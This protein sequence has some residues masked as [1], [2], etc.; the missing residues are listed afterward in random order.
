VPF[1]VGGGGAGSPS[2]LTQCG[3]DRGLPPYQ[4]A[5]LDPSSR[6]VT[7]DIGRK[8]GAGVPLL[9]GKELSPRLTQ[10]RLGRGLPPY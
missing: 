3:L 7:T 10:S 1:S 5:Y 6:L 9:S 4:V 2:R 8:L